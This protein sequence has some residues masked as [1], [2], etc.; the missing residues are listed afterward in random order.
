MIKPKDIIEIDLILKDANTKEL[1]DTTKKE[2]AKEHN[3]NLK[4]QYQPLSYIFGTGE[5]LK[6]VEENISELSLNSTKTFILK[7]EQAFKD[8]DPSKIELVSL[9]DFKKENIKPEIGLFVNIK[10]KSGKVISI[11]GGR[12]RVDFNPIFAGKDLEYT[13][14]LNK[15]ISDD[16]EKLPLLLEKSFYFMPKEQLTL[17]SNNNTVELQ[18][19]FGIPQELD[20]FKQF[21]SKLIFDSTSFTQVKFTQLLKKKEWIILNKTLNTGTTTIGIHSKDGIVLA[22]DMQVSVGNLAVNTN[23]TKIYKINDTIAITIAGSVGDAIV[24]VRHLQNHANL[25]ELEH[26]KRL[27]TK[28]C[29]TLLSNILNSHKMLPFFSQLIVAGSDNQLYT[30]DMMGGYTDQD[31]FAFSGSG[32]ELA[33]SILDKYYKPNLSIKEAIDIAKE[34]I[35]SAKKRDL[36]TGGDGIKIVLVKKDG[37]EELPIEHYK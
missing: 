12:V 29:V 22:A 31:K 2:V 24:L 1:L 7:K 13:I 37:I 4:N 27:S 3:L 36:F 30:L 6:G 26:N 25:Y 5:L 17:T 10:N 21:F 23:T 32:S 35:T 11:S 14:T 8:R 16:S 20:Y 15:I 34:A 18:M 9:N 28:S 19:P 33:L